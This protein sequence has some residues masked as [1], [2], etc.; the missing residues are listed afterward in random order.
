MRRRVQKEDDRSFPLRTRVLRKTVILPLKKPGRQP[1]AEHSPTIRWLVVALC[2]VI[3]GFG[4]STAGAADAGGDQLGITSPLALEPAAQADSQIEVSPAAGLRFWE[5]RSQRSL[6]LGIDSLDHGRAVAAPGRYTLVSPTDPH[7]RLPLEALGVGSDQQMVGLTAKRQPIIEARLHLL[8]PYPLDPGHDYRLDVSAVPTANGQTLGQ[9]AAAVPVA[10][11]PD[12]RSSSI[13]VNQIGYAPQAR[14]YG[15]LGN[16]LGTLGPLPLEGLN[17]EVISATTG[18]AVFQGEARLRAAADPWSGND[19][20]EVDFSALTTPGRYRLR[21][22]GL[23]VSDP[24]TIAP[25]VYAPA[26]RALLRL[27]YHSRNA[28]PITPPWADPGYARPQG[29]VPARLDGVFHAAVATCP[30]GN[31]EPAGGY[32]ALSRGWFDAGDFGQYVVNL[33]PIWYQIG[34]G[35]DLAPQAFRDG[36][37]GIPESG[38]G[39]PDVLDELEWGMDWLLSMQDPRDGGVYSRLAS[40]TWDSV[41]PHL[42]EEPRVIFEKTSHAT[43]I[44]AAIAASHAHMLQDYRPARADA[45][46]KAAEKAWDF[47]QT[48]PQWPAEGEPYRNP[49]GIHAGEYGDPSLRDNLLWASAELFRT[50]GRERYREAYRRLVKGLKLDPTGNVS[51]KD[52][53]LA[54]LW[55]WLMAFYSGREQQ[56]EDQNLVRQAREVL[57]AAADWRIRRAEEHPFRAPVHQAIQLVGWGSFARSTAATLPLLQA[58]RLTEEEH[59]R[60]WAWL[61]PHP[62]LGANPQ[63]LSYITGLGGRSPRFPLSKLSQMDDQAAPLRGI[64]VHGPHFHLPALWGEMRAVNAA[65]LPPEQPGPTQPKDPEDFR[66]SYPVLRRYT[67]VDALPPMSEPTVAEYA[68]VGVAFALLSHENLI[69]RPKAMEH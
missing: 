57:I 7:Y 12:R 30:L 20:Y 13:Q 41:P 23:G 9:V 50:T 54:A 1:L 51:Y 25:D 59:Y 4:G 43:A 6:T 27:F 33:G 38:N 44:F 48:H 31:E 24:F 10:Y 26:Y 34:A 14:K 46:L 45:V 49:P 64:P 42:I 5:T 18:E 62:Q 8:F 28:T 21:V 16:W 58:Y 40:T 60:D 47:L 11:R 15:Y 66:G 63:G 52:Q 22:A 39:V 35:L 19:V 67:D 2:L 36:E 61:T 53:A 69:P 29:G 17:F 32:R 37:L 68:Q 56:P 65:Y 55:A 3:A